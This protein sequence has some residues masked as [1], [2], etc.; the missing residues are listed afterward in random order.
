[1]IRQRLTIFGTSLFLLAATMLTCAAYAENSAVFSQVNLIP[2]ANAANLT[3]F[4]I[5]N[6]FELSATTNISGIRAW[7]SDAFLGNNNNR[8][9]NFSGTIGFAFY[10]D[11]S[12]RPGA[13]IASGH[14]EQTVLTDAGF[15]GGG[16]VDVMAVDADI[17]N[18]V[19]GP[20]V[21]WL[22]LHEGH[23]LEPSD[24]STVAWYVSQS[25]IGVDVGF[26]SRSFEDGFV[27]SQVRT[28]ST[29]SSAEHNFVV[30]G[31]VVVPEPSSLI[32][33][34]CSAAVSCTTRNR[35]RRKS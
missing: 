4:I 7:I 12:G 16:S 27:T 26:G 8:L 17:P 32:L 35:H 28:W 13:F 5:A 21:Y 29:G 33:L 19:L 23:W 14:D 10:R 15:Q 18:L 6:D 25:A 11:N 34:A 1:M 22:A 24:G 9:D 2:N 3:T 30:F 20:G 31:T